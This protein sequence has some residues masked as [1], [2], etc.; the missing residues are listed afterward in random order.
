MLLALQESSL[1]LQPVPRA[2]PP[3][4]EAAIAGRALAPYRDPVVLVTRPDG[5]VERVALER[6]GERFRGVF[7]CSPPAARGAFQ[8]EV[9]ADDAY[10]ETVLANFPVHCGEPAPVA[11]AP[12][13]AAVEERVPSTVAEIEA[14]L[15]ELLGLD[16]E[17]AGLPPL[18]ADARLAAVA[19]AHAADMR[20]HGFFGHV[21]PSTGSPEDRVRRAGFAP[22]E[23]RENLAR[24]YTPAEL[25]RG[26]MDSPAHRANIL[27]RTVDRV[28]IGVVLGA[29]D[30]GGTREIYLTQLFAHLPAPFDPAHADAALAERLQAL[31]AEAHARTLARDP[32]LDE[33]ARQIASDLAGGGAAP[34]GKPPEPL[35]RAMPAL[36]A[37]YR[38]VRT[39]I[40]RVEEI[41]QLTASAPLVDRATTDA[42]LAVARAEKDPASGRLWLVLVLASRK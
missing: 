33:V 41:A 14:R 27:A 15:A 19:R 40:A 1:E 4:G 32:A 6:D 11:L 31:R 13:R 21:S 2:L 20:E 28:G 25:E 18:A 3:G 5:A 7:R 24:A 23:V 34:S 16:R 37:R 22:L 17:R 26:L 10:G 29:D 36:G 42:G 39:A 8:I 38:A 35:R 9:A 30:G 12:A